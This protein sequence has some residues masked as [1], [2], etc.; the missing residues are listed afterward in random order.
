MLDFGFAQNPQVTLVM[1]TH[2]CRDIVAEALATLAAHTEP[3]YELIIVDSA[4]PDT[5][6]VWIESHVR[7]ARFIRS[8]TN[9]GYGAGSN[10]GARHARAPLLLFLNPDVFVTPTW[11]P[12]LIEA[13]SQP[14]VGVAGPQLRYPNGRLQAAG[15][16]V[17]RTGRTARYGDG[18]PNPDAAA[19][20]YP[21]TVDYVSGACLMTSRA[22]FEQLDGFDPIFGLGYF[23]DTDLC[24]RIA[25]LGH[26][27]LYAP[28]SIVHHVRDAS[29]GSR[30]LADTVARNHK[31]FE[32]RWREVLEFRPPPD[33][34]TDPSVVIKARD[35]R[36]SQRVLLLGSAIQ[37]AKRLLSDGRELAITVIGRDEHDLT[38]LV[39]VVE[40]CDDWP[41]WFQARRGHY[42][43]VVGHDERFESLVSGLTGSRERGDT[44][45]T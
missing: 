12:P 4:S 10:L 44:E 9:I 15:S 27:V 20:R 2:G 31:V 6:A 37:Q 28:G 3:D 35:I 29:G 11:L 23:E 17:F 22:L 30:T 42:D 33:L 7:G 8:D 13:M 19:Y 43:L 45:A 5:T 16:L 24:F 34:A 21:R 26:R 18:D 25:E 1:V 40:T 14:R 39:E 36:A 32:E 38:H 41:S